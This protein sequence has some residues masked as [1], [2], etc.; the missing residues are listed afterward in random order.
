MAD[1]KH[2]SV[3]YLYGSDRGGETWAMITS[4]L[5][6]AKLHGLNPYAYLKD[7][8]TRIADSRLSELGAVP[9]GRLEAGA[10]R[11]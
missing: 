10:W 2:L 4:L 5:Y 8:L 3:G 11:W 7:V 6:S 9:A 1:Q